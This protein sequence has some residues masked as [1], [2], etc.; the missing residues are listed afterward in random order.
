VGWSPDGQHVAIATIDYTLRLWDVSVPTLRERLRAAS[1]D[2]LSPR[3][4]Q[5]YLDEPVAK[6]Q[7]RYDACE[8]SHGRT[9]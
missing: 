7:E 8:R 1:T 9:P 4:R 2:C 6:A 5:D 3:M